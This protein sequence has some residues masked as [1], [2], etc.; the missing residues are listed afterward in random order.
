LLTVFLRTL[1]RRGWSVT[2]D[3]RK[4]I[5]VRMLGQTI[6]FAVMEITKRILHEKDTRPRAY[7]WGPTYDY[8]PT[9]MLRLRLY[10]AYYGTRDWDGT[11]ERPLETRLND[12]IVGFLKQAARDRKRDEELADQHRRWEH[13]RRVREQAEERVRLE[14]AKVEKLIRDAERWEQARL[15]RAYVS[16]VLKS[17][18][19]ERDKE[20]ESD[21]EEWALAVADQI[22]P[23]LQ[24]GKVV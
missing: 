11:A 9:G 20:S 14:K 6:A 1:E 2:E 12:V 21:W 5:A 8:E 18:A 7:D 15:I 10:K 4:G 19:V 3:E 22:D 16:E 24:A 23:A 17:R 13:G